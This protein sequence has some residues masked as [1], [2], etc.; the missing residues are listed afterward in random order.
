MEPQE[1]LM[2]KCNLIQN[3]PLPCQSFKEEPLG[4]T[5]KIISPTM[6]QEEGRWNPSVADPDPLQIKGERGGAVI[7]TLTLGGGTICKKYFFGPWG[8]ILVEK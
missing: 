7:Q 6:V 5:R 2:K 4:R 1:A 3:Q 8:L